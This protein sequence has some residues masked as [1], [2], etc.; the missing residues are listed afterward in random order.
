MN[1][2]LFVMRRQL[3][4]FSHAA[5]LRLRHNRE[6]WPA[7]YKSVQ[8]LFVAYPRCRRRQKYEGNRHL[9]HGGTVICTVPTCFLKD[10]SGYILVN[11]AWLTLG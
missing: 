11:F 7:A 6:R 1:L 10:R 8:Q 4:F 3:P 2:A 5:A 9:H